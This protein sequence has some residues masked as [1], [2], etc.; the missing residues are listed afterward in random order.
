M[1]ARILGRMRQLVLEQRYIV[2]LH[3]DEEMD[4]DGLSVY[5]VE[6]VVLCGQIVERQRDAATSE[7]K[8]RIRG[9]TLVGSEAEVITKLSIT[10]KLVFITAYSL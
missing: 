7:Y 5:D 1:Y 2:T 6:S 9:Q 8:Y 3:A 4:V 10:G